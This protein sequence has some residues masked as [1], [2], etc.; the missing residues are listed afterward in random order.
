M[1]DN[2]RLLNELTQQL[3]VN[4]RQLRADAILVSNARARLIAGVLAVS[5]R[6]RGFCLPVVCRLFATRSRFGWAQWQLV[7]N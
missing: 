5:C 4:F 7:A 3:C 6:L 1:P 2:W